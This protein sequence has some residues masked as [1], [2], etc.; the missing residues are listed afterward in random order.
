MLPI[1]QPQSFS[2]E[3]RQLVER[4]LA[5][6]LVEIGLDQTK[7]IVL[8]HPADSSRGDLS[9]PVAMQLIR[10]LTA[11]Q[12]ERFH[13]P[14]ELAKGIVASLHF[15]TNEELKNIV[16]SVEA[17]AP[18]FINFHYSQQ[19][20]LQEALLLVAKER[21]GLDAQSTASEKRTVIEYVSP[22]TNKPLHIGHLRNAALGWSLSKL[23]A[24]GGATVQR[25]IIFND[26][27]LHIMKSCWGYLAAGRQT[28][29]W[30]DSLL[31]GELTDALIA[32]ISETLLNGATQS[33]TS[34]NGSEGSSFNWQKTVVEWQVAT[35]DWLQPTQMREARLQKSDHFIGFWYQLAERFADNESV[36]KQWSEMLLCW[37]D[38]THPEH[39][40]LRQLWSAMNDWF[41]QGFEETRQRFVFGFDEGSTS[42]E[43]QIYQKGKDIVV[44][45]ADQG[46]LERLPDGAVT[47]RLEDAGLPDKILLR[48]DGTGIYM[49]FDIE[50][51]RQRTASNA[52][53]LI[54]IVGVDQKLYFQQLFAVAEKLGYGEK[55]RYYHLP[56]GMVRLP[57]GKMSS[58]KGLV[59]YADDIL[60]LAVDQARA[61]MAEN[62]SKE[63]LDPMLFEQVAEA[64]GIGAVKWTMLSVDALSEITFDIRS[65]VSFKGFAG[66]YVQYTYA[67]CQSVLRQANG[68]IT[69]DFDILRNILIDKKELQMNDAELALLRNIYTYYETFRHSAEMLAPHILCSY[70]YELCQRFNTFYAVCPIVSDATLAEPSKQL[71]LLLTS[72]TASI[73]AEGLTLLGITVVERM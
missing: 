4:F 2:L 25:A 49:T 17:V 32:D 33:Q 72:A 15:D 21:G 46:I 14:L 31:S 67:R 39:A 56:Y 3:A 62:G 65:S 11:E 48:R 53:K 24:A 52:Q 57:E 36:V 29:T 70:L 61:I 69:I 12:R 19:L 23:L 68:A 27:G 58:R 42:Y 44:A 55:E 30:Q 16:S 10:Q 64:V 37:E 51:T 60:E 41:Y 22:N 43:S 38:E 13:S 66:P 59:L 47:A 20:L 5:E 26:R 8:E 71:R 18:G 35:E 40:Q 9:S 45:A 50:L 7:E 73:L 54:W 6:A 34:Q 63:H 1:H 28:A